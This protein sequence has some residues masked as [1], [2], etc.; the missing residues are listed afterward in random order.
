MVEQEILQLRE[1]LNEYA[2]LYYDLDAPAVSDYEY[3]MLMN[4]LKALEAEHPELVTPDSP[5]QR[6]GGHVLEQFEPVRHPVPLMSLT[7]VFSLD[8][9]RAF[10]RRI[11][12][13]VEAPRYVL[14]W[15]IDGLSVAL[16]Y[17]DGV[18]VRGATRGDGVTGEDVTQNL[19]TVRSIPLQI[20]DAPHRVIVRGEVYM[21]RPRFAKLNV[22]REARGESLFA[23]PRNAAAGSLRQ[24]DP[25]IAAERGLDIFVFNLQLME[26]G[27]E[28]TGHAQTLEWLAAHGFTVSPDY[29]IYDD[30]ESVCARIDEMEALRD[31]LGFGTD[32]AVVKVDSLADRERLGNTAKA[33]KWAVAY[34]Y[35][36]EEAKTRLLDITVTVGRTGVLTPNA[37]LEPV[38]LAGTTVS[39]ASLHNLDWIRER[40]LRVGDLV[41]VRK[42]GEI[43]PE[44]VSADPSSRPEGALPFQMPE[45]ERDEDMAAI[46]CTGADCPT[47]LLRRLVHFCSRDA[48]DI[49]GCGP[50]V[51]QSLIDENL[52]RDP[53]DLYTLDTEKVASLPRMGEKSAENL[54]RAVEAS[55]SRGMARL[56]YAFGIRQV[57]SAAADTLAV[58]FGSLEELMEADE[59]TLTA[60]PDIGGTTAAYI[61]AW[62]TEDAARDLVARLKALG[63]DTASHSEPVSDKLAGMTFVLTGTLSKYTRSQ[64]SQLI[65]SLGGK[66]AGSVSKKTTY[67]V[68]GEDAGSK[69]AKAEALGVPVLDEDGLESLIRAE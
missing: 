24:L 58:R 50:A 9:V 10:D 69:L 34:K 1:Q 67:V 52:V 45:V 22:V 49:E 60:I 7:D 53:A 35:P 29:R 4:R 56:L 64:A 32:G 36:P 37:V 30:I 62:A 3:D 31:G 54:L 63:V 11:R 68:A 13:S 33:P 40:D 15:K 12:E 20:P 57:G 44:I 66:V 2:R 51:L 21:S 8:E 6:V 38:R 16:E 26:G 59:E 39:R 55:R 46:R 18:F 42:A 28:L 5:T 17:I 61:R 23:N 43:I 27:P 25:K 65:T 41:T 47:Q 48:M 19:R 14:E